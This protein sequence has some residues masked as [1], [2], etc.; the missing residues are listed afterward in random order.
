[1][2]QTVCIQIA[3]SIIYGEP[4]PGMPSTTL[5]KGKNRSKNH[6][7]EEIL[8]LSI[9]KYSETSIII[10]AENLIIKQ[11]WMQQSLSD[12]KLKNLLKNSQ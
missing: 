10:N 11:L 8:L 12:V 3:L 2:N 1:M 7:N 4:S 5:Q 9:K 6:Y